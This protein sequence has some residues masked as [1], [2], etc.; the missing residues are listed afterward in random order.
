MAFAVTEWNSTPIDLGVDL[1]LFDNLTEQE[2]E[3]IDTPL[4][5][6]EKEA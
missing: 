4:D 3:S 5:I 2:L 6:S 1:E